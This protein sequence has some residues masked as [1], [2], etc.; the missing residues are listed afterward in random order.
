VVIDASLGAQTAE[1]A[2]TFDVSWTP[3]DL[4]RGRLSLIVS[5]DLTSEPRLSVGSTF[6]NAAQIFSIPVDA[7]TGAASFPSAKQFGYPFTSMADFPEGPVNVQVRISVH[8]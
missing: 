6:A 5:R 7:T 2:A 1:V 4:Q 8:A 3:G